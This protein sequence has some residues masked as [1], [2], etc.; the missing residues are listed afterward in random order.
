MV[1]PLRQ[2]LASTL[3][4][5]AAGFALSGCSGEGET[6]DADGLGVDEIVYVVREHTAR[7]E[8]GELQINVADGM[9]QVMDHGR[10]VPGARI[11]VRNVATGET[12][13]LLDNE[14]RFG[15]ADVSG[16]DL[17]FDATRVVFSMKLDGDDN[18]HLYVANLVRGDDADNPFGVRQLTSGPQDDLYPIWLAG[19]RI[20]FSTT[21]GY[22]EMGLRADEYNH[23]RQVPQIAVITE[24]GGEADRKLCSQN[25]SN[26]FDL[27]AMSS[28]QVG[29]SRWE[30]LEN[31]NDSKLFAMHPDCTQMVAVAGQHGKE[32]FNSLVQVVETNDRNVF[33]AVATERENTLQAGS[34]V[35]VDARAEAEGR[36]D[37]EIAGYEVLTPAVPKDDAPSPI[38][39]YRTPSVLPDG[40]LLV[41]WAD[42]EVNE[43]NE[44][45]LTPPDWGLYVYDAE[46]RENDLV[47]NDEDTWEIFA[48]PVVE[49]PEP[50]VLGSTQASQDAT[51]PL[52]LG[53]INVART[54]LGELHGNTVTGAQFD[55]TPI[56]EALRQAVKVR[57]IEGFSSEAAI[58]VNMF[59]LTMAE[60]AAIVGEATV[61]ADGSWLA[62]VPPFIPY[63]LQPIDEFELSIRNQTTWIQGMPGEARVC[64]GCHERR[65]DANIPTAQQLPLAQGQRETFMLGI[66]DRTEY[67]WALAPN[68]LTEVQ[69]ILS[70]RCESCHNET[71]NGSGP[72]EFYT[73][74]MTDPE[75]G[76]VSSYPIPRLDLSSRA[77]AVVY[78][79][80]LAEY[81]AS[82][83][84]L[85]YPSA[86][87]MEMGMTATVQ[88]TLP[89][90]WAIPSDARNSAL[91]EKLN[92]WAVADPNR[93]AWE[94][95]VAYSNPD[96][97]G[98]ARTLHPEDVGGTLTREERTALIRAIDIGGQYYSRQN[99]EF[100]PYESNPL[101]TTG[102]MY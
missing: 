102:T 12:R 79:D 68:S 93:T 51:L 63:H 31:V 85:F 48:R 15:R 76:A 45:D 20:A 6:T 11:E 19:G 82:Y 46:R 99:S 41:S 17:S 67:P 64:G 59:G 43:F 92:M 30:H 70:A 35:V 25:L 73:L 94:L 5:A 33:V 86:I 40:R 38:G 60:G 24:E 88:G 50:P 42:G 57:I 97:R 72:Q 54:S 36:H 22:T 13:N 78:D 91:I 49:R 61:H 8:A 55:G 1:N 9:G 23:S 89:P 18:Y 29:F 83:V 34:L 80:E 81:A 10:Y 98:A 39:R 66:A 100:V 56:D 47:F 90:E 44:R 37:E 95:G 26:S 14:R 71:T 2:H 7:N 69:K 32:G 16:L 74:S 77:I 65:V 75:T 27:F 4:I 53:S 87:R 84:S 58:G 28:G 3:A 62:R 21:R 52:E 96:I 101:G